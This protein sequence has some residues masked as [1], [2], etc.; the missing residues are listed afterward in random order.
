MVKRAVWLVVCAMAL[1]L[2]VAGGITLA[3]LAWRG[4]WADGCEY[5]PGDVR[6]V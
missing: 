2:S 5:D 4:L 6:R 3:A 1:T